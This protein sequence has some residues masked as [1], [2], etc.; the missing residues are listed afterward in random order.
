MTGPLRL[1]LFNQLTYLLPGVNVTIKLR[2]NINEFSLKTT[3]ANQKPLIKIK[4]INI[5]KNIKTF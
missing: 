2:R 1:N 5:L 4:I 3:E